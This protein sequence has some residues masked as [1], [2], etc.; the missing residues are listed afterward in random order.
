[1]R[2]EATSQ[3][4]T[5]CRGVCSTT[6]YLAGIR[7]DA[8]V[9]LSGGSATIAS[10]A[11]MNPFDGRDSFISTFTL[12]NCTYSHKTANASPRLYIPLCLPLPPYG[13]QNG[14]PPG[15]LRLISNYDNHD[16]SLH[17]FTVHGLRESLRA[18]ESYKRLQSEYPYSRWRLGR[19]ICCGSDYTPGCDQDFI[20]DKRNRARPRITA[21]T[22]FV[23][24]SFNHKKAAGVGR[25]FPWFTASHID[26]R[27]RHCDLLVSRTITP[28]AYVA[29]G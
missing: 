25:I 11:L 10:D 22:R 12:S 20:T 7:A 13:L 14:G 28:R 17:S 6:L 4:I 18:H 27:A 15:F 21:R 9:V 23:W 19:W 2:L 29:D 1:M 26:R 8:A 16:C 5:C 24:G 3:G